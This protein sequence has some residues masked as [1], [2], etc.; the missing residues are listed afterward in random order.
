MLSKRREYKFTNKSHTKRGLLS[1]G[2]GF[3]ALLVLGGL[4]YLSYQQS[5]N[6]DA[7]AGF[8]GSLSMWGSAVGLMLGA[9]SFREEDKFYLFSYVGCI[10]NGALLVGWIILY[11]LG[12]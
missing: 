1:S 2:I 6:V 4:F 11:V 5:G 9:E 7:Y 3:F 12:M 8:L 10:L